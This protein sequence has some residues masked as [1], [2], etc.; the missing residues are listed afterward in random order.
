MHV[1]LLAAADPHPFAG[2]ADIEKAA[3]LLEAVSR[4][5]EAR[6]SLPVSIRLS[7]AMADR[8]ES[9]KPAAF[10]GLRTADVEWVRSGW[11]SP[12][13]P[14]LPET[15]R[16]AQLR[17]E[18]EVLDELGLAPGGCWTGVDW[19]PDLVSS[20]ARNGVDHL[21]MPAELL[22]G[23]C[24]LVEHLGTV[25]PAVPV[26]PIPDDPLAWLDGHASGDP[27]GLVVFVVAE[28]RSLPEAVDMLAGAAGC[29][30]TTPAAYLSRHVVGRKA[31]PLGMAADWQSRLGDSPG[32]ELVY[33]KVLRM[34]RRVNDRVDAHIL[35]H[36]LA[37]QTAVVF[38]PDPDLF[39]VRRAAH[40]SLASAAAVLESR[41]RGDWARVRQ[42]DWDADGRR[43]VHVE[44]P[45]ISAVIDPH[46]GGRVLYIDDKA[47]TWPVTVLPAEEGRLPVA[48]SCRFLPADHDPSKPLPT[49][50]LEATAAGEQRGQVMVTLEGRWGT[51][52]SIRC[53]ITFEDRSL[54]LRYE[55]A[56]L[57]PGR[58]GFEIPLGLEVPDLRMRVDGGEWIPLRRPDALAG[59]RFRITDGDRQVLIGSTAPA[60]CFTRPNDEYGVVVWPHW[61]VAGSGHY[62]LTVDLAP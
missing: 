26:L 19:E 53:V 40:A 23:A 8:I 3:T 9:L 57:P 12:S 45:D 58:F 36:L 16:D 5:V 46:D 10:D 59:H 49:V 4:A 18:A 21:L 27:D 13:L 32:G 11:S 7:A 30:L 42:V 60:D 50:H 41:G 51:E 34:W 39:P 24:G 35:D 14:M 48:T 2:D 54:R 20:L 29:D 33:R 62:E 31:Y 1:A 55:L 47:R 17:R 37:A 28:P 44:L 52:G 25:L 61:L 43:E 6:S 38:D 15:A 22:E 56:G